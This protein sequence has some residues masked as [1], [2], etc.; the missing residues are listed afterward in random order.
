MAEHRHD[1]GIDELRGYFNAVID[2]VEN[3][4]TASPNKAIR[5]PRSDEVPRTFATAMRLC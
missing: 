5:R 4:F 3:V 1:D 2:W